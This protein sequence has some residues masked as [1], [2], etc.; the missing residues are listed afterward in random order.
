MLSRTVNETTRGRSIKRNT[1]NPSTTLLRLSVI[2]SAV[3]GFGVGLTLLTSIALGS[4][5]RLPFEA[6]AQ[7]HGQVQ[8]LGFVGLFIVGTAAVLLPGFLAA[9]LRRQRTILI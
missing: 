4:V 8:A 3:A 1:P 9:P 7:A 2:L 6:L 5:G